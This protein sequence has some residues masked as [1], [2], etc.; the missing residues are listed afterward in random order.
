MRIPVIQAGWLLS[1]LTLAVFPALAQLGKPMVSMA[2]WDARAL[3][4]ADI[5]GDGLNDI[6]F[7]NN[8]RGKVEIL[9]QRD[10][11][12]PDSHEERRTMGDR[13]EPVLE[14]APFTR[15][16]VDALESMYDLAIGDITGDGRADLILTS[17]EAGMTLLAQQDDGNFSEVE[18]FENFDALPWS[19]TVILC[20]YDQDGRNDI[21]QLARGG[22]FLMRQ[23]DNGSLE[24]PHKLALVEDNARA[25]QFLDI[26][27]DGDKDFL[28]TTGM[29]E[30]PLRARLADAS[31]LYGSEI[32]LRFDLASTSLPQFDQAQRAPVFA[33]LYGQDRSAVLFQ[34][35]ANNADTRFPAPTILPLDASVSTDAAYALDDIDGNGF[36]DI[37]LADS[38]SPQL[39]LLQGIPGGWKAPVAYPAQASITSLAAGDFHGGGKPASLLVCAGGSDGFLGI[40]TLTDEGR[41][42]FPQSLTIQRGD[43]SNDYAPQAVVAADFLLPLDGKAEAVLVS[44]HARKR[45]LEIIQTDDSGTNFIANSAIEIDGLR[46]DIESIG[47]ADLNQDGAQ[48]I[49]LFVPR[50]DAIIFLQEAGT[51]RQLSAPGSAAGKDLEGL[52]RAQTALSDVNGDGKAEWLVCATGYARAYRINDDDIL[53]VV[54]QYNARDSKDM[55]TL[56]LRMD[57]DSDGQLEILLYVVQQGAFQ[58]LEADDAGVYRYDRTEDVGAIKPLRALNQINR[59]SSQEPLLIL[60]RQQVWLLEPGKPVLVT[61]IQY[62]RENDLPK[63]IF[64]DI[65]TGDLIHGGQPEML[66]IDGTNNFLELLK[67]SEDGT[68]ESE[69]FFEVFDTD[70]HYQGRQGAPLEPRDV[71]IDDV[72]GDG[73]DDL[74]IL[75]HNRVL[76]YP[77]DKQ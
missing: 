28:Y 14:N 26:N 46:R 2:E 58:V 6:A 55:T 22:L 57:I 60:G 44:S 59:H 3:A 72:T 10:E 4:I 54:D 38:R 23:T 17:N 29:G 52:S 36:A 33:A 16:R 50:S 25:L 20:D 42:A 63:I 43:D 75:V 18:S 77:Q 12:D 76:I 5:D 71:R 49:V 34:I 19:S 64:N 11:A 31:G 67:L 65:A 66:M 47:L 62:E 68:W 15:Q 48:D 53:E 8:D 40:T 37:I 51:F 30:R 13:W 27:G 9:Y 21:A 61:N 32:S 1:S 35:E 24:A 56:P 39:L 7:I 70:A 69:L 45:Y 41:L 73:L 74:I